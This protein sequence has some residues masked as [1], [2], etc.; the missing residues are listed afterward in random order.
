MHTIGF[1]ETQ[2]RPIAC[3]EYASPEQMG[4]ANEELLKNARATAVRTPEE[5]LAWCFENGSQPDPEHIAVWNGFMSKRGWNDEA[6]SGLQTQKQ[7]AG[8]GDRAD[9]VTFFDL[10][11]AEERPA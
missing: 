6:E 4:T 8:L 10:M 5:V 11:D 9:I 7:L 2:R 3:V 1:A